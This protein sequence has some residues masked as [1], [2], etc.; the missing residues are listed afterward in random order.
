M[1]IINE[2]I[3]GSES[4]L[5]IDIIPFQGQSSPPNLVA[6]IIG[7]LPTVIKT[8]PGRGF[9]NDY[10]LSTG[11]KI[12]KDRE[13]LESCSP[14]S[15]GAEEATYT[16]IISKKI[17]L[18]SLR[19]MREENQIKDFRIIDRV[20]DDSLNTW[21]YHNNFL[22]KREDFNL[23]ESSNRSNTLINLLLNHFTS[24]VV[25]NGAG[26]VRQKPNSPKRFTI[27]AGQKLQT[28]E[29]KVSPGTVKEKPIINLRDQALAQV[30]FW[31]RIHDV[32]GDSNISPWATWWNKGST[33]LVLKLHENNMTNF[34]NELSIHDPVM[35][36]RDFA[37]NPDTL[38]T[39]NN[40]KKFRAIDIQE[41]LYT[42]S[43]KMS[44]HIEL[45]PSEL[46]VLEQWGKAINDYRKDPSYL[47]D[48]VDWIL[49]AY[50]IK[51]KELDFKKAK[52][53]D[54]E[55]GNLDSKLVELIWQK[56]IFPEFNK[57]TLSEYY[58]FPP[59]DTRASRRVDILGQVKPSVIDYVDWDEISFTNTD[60]STTPQIAN[61]IKMD[62]PETNKQEIFR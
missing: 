60:N 26:M 22:V 48:R 10:F 59:S 58:Y 45:P 40:N 52:L 4:E 6:S 35:T 23:K 25:F 29:R 37:N 42:Q 17:V 19:R 8:Y 30:Q 36:S 61:L 53:I 7:H 21:G 1:S 57:N 55:F 3:I 32:S 13:F 34:L 15:R 54:L 28:I 49:K 20:I 27:L 38:A 31:G 11:G 43:H 46:E 2:R 39:M 47:K 44:Q 5:A 51:E 18:D 14:E 12:Y 41:I 56:N 16:E 33:S 24:R 9:T 50:I 62:D